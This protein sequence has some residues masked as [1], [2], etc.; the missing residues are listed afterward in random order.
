MINTNPALA[1]F[2]PASKNKNIITSHCDTGLERMGLDKVAH[3]LQPSPST[4]GNHEAK[5]IG[6][7]QLKAVYAHAVSSW[8][9]RPPE[10]HEVGLRPMHLTDRIGGQTI[11]PDQF[12]RL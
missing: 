9:P 6:Q 4:P 5:A 10:E 3:C 7:E 12:C 1:F 11:A 8:A 2:Y